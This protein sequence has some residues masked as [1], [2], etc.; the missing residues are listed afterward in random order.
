VCCTLWQILYNDG[1]QEILN[2]SKE[3]W[4]LTGKQGKTSSAKKEKVATRTGF[5]GML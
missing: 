2:L 3:R 5:L 1:E 4:E